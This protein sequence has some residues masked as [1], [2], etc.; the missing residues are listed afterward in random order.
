MTTVDISDKMK[1]AARRGEKRI[2][3]HFKNDNN[4][5]GLSEPD[6]FYFGILGELA[7]VY[8]LKQNG[9]MAKYTP[10]WDG[11]ADSGDV[12]VYCDGDPLKVD[13]KTCSKKFHEN[14]WIPVKQYQRYSYNGYIGVRL[15]GDVAEIHGYCSKDKF[16]KTEH[17]G[18]KVANYGIA[19]TELRPLDRLFPKLDKG[20]TIIKL[21]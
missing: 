4:Y 16:A 13:V 14:L 15:N 3:S 20:E 19:L 5:T 6:R 17:S 10:A 18:A 2:L 9:I 7:F 1:A 12:I 21:P 8:V 11:K